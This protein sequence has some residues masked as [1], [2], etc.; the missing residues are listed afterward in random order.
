M[1]IILKL[2]TM[3]AYNYERKYVTYANPIP[4]RVSDHV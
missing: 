3:K 4:K 2:Q 1:T